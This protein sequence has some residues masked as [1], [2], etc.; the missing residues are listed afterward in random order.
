MPKT[1]LKQAALEAE[2][3]LANY[4]AQASLYPDEERTL[5]AALNIVRKDASK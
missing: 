3:A 4:R 5:D 2:A 1:T